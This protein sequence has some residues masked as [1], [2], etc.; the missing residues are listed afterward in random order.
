M[1]LLLTS[2]LA[3]DGPY[4]VNIALNQLSDGTSLPALTTNM[5]GVSRSVWY[6]SK[7]LD[8]PSSTPCLHNPG[9]N[10]AAIPSRSQ[11]ASD[12][13]HLSY[14][15]FRLLVGSVHR[16]HPGDRH[17]APSRNILEPH[18]QPYNRTASSMDEYCNCLSL[19]PVESGQNFTDSS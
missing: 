19:E 8:T 16:L 9:A 5:A 12:S 18:E 17:R 13:V 2:S 6:P 10:C 1:C 14:R 4:C 11:Y 3:D 15:Y 7:R